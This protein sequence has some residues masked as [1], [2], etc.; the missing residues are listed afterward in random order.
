MIIKALV[1]NTSHKKELKA[2][3]GLSIYIE[4]E[5]HKILFDAGASAAFA[6]NAAK[7]EIDLS[8][9]EIMVLSHGHYDHGG[10]LGTFL[11]AN[12]SAKVYIHNKA[13]G[14]FY[15]NKPNGEKRYI[16][17]DKTL[18]PNSR[19][20]FTEGHTELDRE[21]EL[22]SSV[23][24]TRSLPSGNTDLL[25]KTDE[26]YKRDDFAH[27]QNLIIHE[28][29]KTVLLAG[30]AHNGIVNILEHFRL[31]EGCYPD[32]VIGGFH[33]Y[34]RASD[35]NEPPAIVAEIGRYLLGTG[36]QYYTCHCTGTRSYDQLKTI[37]GAKI[38]YLS[39]G[40]QIII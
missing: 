26:G 17:L 34:N 37:M 21:L 36:A 7:M 12:S 25:I 5:K 33:L 15:S 4:T 23:T 1:E 3:H 35:T 9:V 10:G 22:F 40:S 27:E 31:Q 38:D 24:G 30:C 11:D 13:F 18:I 29:G 6:E 14:E 39:S 16:G 20:V 28:K 2:E 8:I 32:A 19:F